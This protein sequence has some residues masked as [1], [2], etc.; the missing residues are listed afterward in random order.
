MSNTSLTCISR[1]D[2]QKDSPFLL[3]LH[4]CVL[5]LAMVDFLKHIW[6]STRKE[7]Q[8]MDRPQRPLN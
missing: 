5:C 1:K 8:R 3:L 2:D 7:G 6:Y 4:L